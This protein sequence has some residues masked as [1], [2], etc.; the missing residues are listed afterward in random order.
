V[1]CWLE[2]NGVEAPGTRFGYVGTGVQAGV[3]PMTYTASNTDDVELCESVLF[4][5]NTTTGDTCF[6]IDDIQIPPQVLWDAVDTVFAVVNDAEGCN[7]SHDECSVV[8]AQLPRLA[9]TYG[10]VTIGPDG[11]VYVADPLG[12]GLNR[13]Y[14]CPPYGNF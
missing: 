9:G 12:L 14:D 13:L 2:V 8:C 3:N 5:D 10:P 11:D 1:T 7:A 4:G 6:P